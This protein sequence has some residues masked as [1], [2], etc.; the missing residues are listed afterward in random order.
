MEVESPGKTLSPP[1]AQRTDAFSFMTSSGDSAPTNQSRRT[2]AVNQS[3]DHKPEV[4][5]AGDF[6]WS[7]DL[8]NS[9]GLELTEAPDVTEEP[10]LNASDELRD[11]RSRSANKQDASQLKNFVLSGIDSDASRDAL[12]D[13]EETSPP[14]AGEKPMLTR[15]KRATAAAALLAP[16]SVEDSEKIPDSEPSKGRRKRLSGV[17]QSPRRSSPRKTNTPKKDEVGVIEET[18]RMSAA[19]GRHES[20]DETPPP[21][22]CVPSSQVLAEDSEQFS[23]GK[24]K[25]VA[26]SGACVEESQLFSLASTQSQDKADLKLDFKGAFSSASLP[27]TSS[28]TLFSE[29]LTSVPDTEGSELSSKAEVTKFS[30]PTKKAS[31]GQSVSPVSPVV[32]VYKLTEEDITR[33]SPGKQPGGGGPRAVGRGVKRRVSL[34]RA[35]KAKGDAP[36]VPGTGL[37][38]PPLNLDDV[39]PSSQDSFS[40]AMKNSMVVTETQLTPKHDDAKDKE[41]SGTTPAK[42]DTESDMETTVIENT[43]K[44]SSKQTAADSDR[45]KT[46][47]S[48]GQGQTGSEHEER[49]EAMDVEE[50]SEQKDATASDSTRPSSSGDSGCLD[51]PD[52]EPVDIEV[53]AESAD[54]QATI[55]GGRV[56][57]RKSRKTRDELKGPSQVSTYSSRVS[58]RLGSV[59]VSGQYPSQVTTRLIPTSDSAWVQNGSLGTQ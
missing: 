27:D 30:T 10:D 23:P 44:L 1:Q 21:G 29:E 55:T 35:G 7:S 34:L 15:G 24:F 31:A 9:E 17:G 37:G 42:S 4:K 51:N 59:L 54:S 22:S 36:Q 19:R 52:I 32:K 50:D 18:L 39:I 2:D 49:P 16:D 8:E 6:R 48:E 3:G 40:F 5:K 14:A 28:K 57:R 56:Q 45:T 53:T 20:E 12:S 41:K 38:A 13:T 58:T 26:D 43:R 11:A 47:G 46:T 25:A 33:L